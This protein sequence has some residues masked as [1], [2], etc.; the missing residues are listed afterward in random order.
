MIND[1]NKFA[2]ASKSAYEYLVQIEKEL[3]EL[4]GQ[5]AKIASSMP[6]SAFSQLGSKYMMKMYNVYTEYFANTILNYCSFR[7]S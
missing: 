6:S 2:N 1:I 7:T 3:E 4:H 5:L